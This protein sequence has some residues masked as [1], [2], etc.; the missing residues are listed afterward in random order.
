MSNYSTSDCL[1]FGLV[2]LF[3]IGAL[4]AGPSLETP[5]VPEEKIRYLQQLRQKIPYDKGNRDNREGV[6]E[7]FSAPGSAMG[8]V[9]PEMLRLYNS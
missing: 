7:H 2:I 5:H 4:V 1:T 8:Q 9:N 3:L 6:I